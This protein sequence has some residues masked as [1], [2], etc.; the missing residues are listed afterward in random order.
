MPQRFQASGSDSGSRLDRFLASRTPGISRTRLQRFI[1]NGLVHI[2]GVPALQPKTKISQGDVV[3]FEIPEPAPLRL[4]PE[5]IKLDILYE[6]EHLLVINK[7]AGMVVHPGAGHETG[8]VVHALLHHCTDLSGIGDRMRPG[9]VHRLDRDTSGIL[10]VAKTQQ[11]H[12]SL[13]AQFACRSTCKNY[14]ALVRGKPSSLAGSIA[15][16]IGRNPA[17]RKKMAAIPGGR[18][19]ITLWKTIKKLR[20]TSLLDIRILTGRT[21][22]IRVHMAS[23]GHP[24]IGDTLYGGPS[25]LTVNG[26]QIKIPRQM[27][28]AA[29]LELT[30]PATGQRM[31]W[32]APLPEDMRKVTELLG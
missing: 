7:A 32:K 6:D 18:E 29:R 3:E 11:A 31:C 26:E 20:G 16:P 28:H 15:R 12:H 21:H 5:N 14:L 1:K 24:V 2:N 4:E 22:Q 10:V 30:H 17:H 8:T 27:L 25:H 9:I 19:A 13:V 23:E